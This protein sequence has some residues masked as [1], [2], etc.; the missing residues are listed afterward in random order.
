MRILIVKLG[1]I[2]DVV[3]CLPALSYI[4]EKLPEAE[5]IWAVEEKA[6]GIL[7]KNPLIDKIILL[8]SRSISALLE[9]VYNLRRL[10]ASV[11]LDF[12]G[13][14]KSSF[15][16]FLSGSKRR[17]GFASDVLRE[18]E[19]R[20]FLS[21][22][23]EI[24]QKTHVIK[25]NLLLVSKAFGFDLLPERLQF[26]IFTEQAEKREATSVIE[27]VGESFAILN[28][29]A[30]WKTKL[31]NAENFGFLADRLWEEFG[32]ES[33]VSV[34]RNE[35]D[36]AQRVL[37]ASKTK[38]TVLASLSLKGFYELA[39]KAKI[40][41][42]G[43]TGPTHIAV[44]AGTP[45]VGIFGPTEWWRNGSPYREDI[46]VERRDIACRVN[47]HR[48]SCGNWICMNIS[49]DHVFEAVRRRLLSGK[50]QTLSF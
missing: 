29:A 47:C 46:C 22:Q 25:K 30:A 42:G 12:Q 37:Q 1:S 9:S 20:F 14:L 33:V 41:V 4:R 26:P 40:Y 31:W 7:E 38:Q 8:K 36:L 24:P 16:A 35:Y 15:L 28:P 43:D 10:G 49:V 6:Y 21:E 3:H 32:I 5:I 17:I 13:L 34:A 48:R 39:K 44:A 11:A 45:I 50:S 2:G 19:S 18:P 27:L 23:V